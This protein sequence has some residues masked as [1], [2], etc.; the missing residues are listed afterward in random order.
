MLV[1][2][3]RDRAIVHHDSVLA[4]HQS[5][6]QAAD[7]QI[8][9]IVAVDALQKL[10]CVWALHVDLAERSDVDQT[11][12]VAHGQTLAPPRVV[13]TLA[14]ALVRLG[15]HPV[16]DRGHHRAALQMPCV[17]RRAP[18]RGLVFADFGACENSQGYRCVRRTEGGRAD[19]R[20][21]LAAQPGHDGQ[22]VDVGSLA[23]VGSHAQRGVALEVFDRAEILAVCQLQI[24]DHDVVLDVDEALAARHPGRRMPHRLDASRRLG[25]GHRRRAGRRAITCHA[26]RV[27]AGAVALRERVCQAELAIGGARWCDRCGDGVRHEAGDGVVK[28]QFAPGLRVQ[29]HGRAPAARVAQQI[30]R[31]PR[32][33]G[34]VASHHAD[35]SD[36][37]ATHRGNAGVGVVVDAGLRQAREQPGVDAGARVDDRHLLRAGPACVERAAV[38]VVV[39][40][41]HGHAPAR[42]HRVLVGISA[43]RRRQHHTGLVVVAKDQRPFDAASGHHDL[44]R[45]QLDQALA[46]Q[47]GRGIGQV[48]G[49][50]FGDRNQVVVVDAE[51]RAARQQAHIT[52]RCELRDRLR[53][54]ARRRLVADLLV[55][56]QQRTSQF[57]PLVSEHDARAT[58]RRRQRGRQSGSAAAGNQHVA[59]RELD[60]VVLG[61][62]GQRRQA[63][64]GRLADLALVEH[65]EPWRPHERLVVKARRHQPGKRLIDA[66]P[67]ERQ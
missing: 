60:R 49:D 43:N 24:L 17:Q 7:R 34:A 58:A 33:P 1:G 35:R 20:N 9:E 54:P 28:A 3:T 27:H 50:A 29:V 2:Q 13:K 18:H 37:R 6:T 44:P 8:G 56:P 21:R 38:G 26:G 4:Q 5:I 10:Q 66:A 53:R 52:H 63:E 16:A 12:L 55:F 39:V 19:R 67:V 64:P 14:L 46:W 48:V 51:D 57:G 62:L 31:E 15:A 25:L 42:K 30:A 22:A 59:M 36:R 45:P 32:D 11:D 61:V 23:L 41:E 40:G 47:T 65:P